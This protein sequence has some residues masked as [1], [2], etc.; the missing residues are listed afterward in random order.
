MTHPGNERKLAEWG[1]SMLSSHILYINK[2]K[3]YPHARIEEV[4]HHADGMLLSESR[5]LPRANNAA[6]GGVYRRSTPRLFCKRRL[7]HRR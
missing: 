5:L 2:D 4:A 7:S 1:T 6:H 3:T